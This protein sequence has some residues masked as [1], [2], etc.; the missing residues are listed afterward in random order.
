MPT[1]TEEQIREAAARLRQAG[2]A[3]G[4][5][6]EQTTDEILGK[7]LDVRG[8]DQTALANAS[9]TL[10]EVFMPAFERSLADLPQAVRSAAADRIQFIRERMAFLRLL[11]DLARTHFDQYVAVHDGRVVDFDR[12]QHVLVLRFFSKFGDDASVYIGFVGLH[13]SRARV[14]TPFYRQSQ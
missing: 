5:A 3:E 7:L 12:S 4:K 11:P 2:A 6:L 8:V 9:R 14:P 10:A 1:V 13:Q